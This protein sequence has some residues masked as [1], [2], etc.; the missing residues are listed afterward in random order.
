MPQ[1]SPRNMTICSRFG[2]VCFQNRFSRSDHQWKYGT[3]EIK[4]KTKVKNPKKCD[5]WHFYLH[6][7][8]LYM[9]MSAQLIFFIAILRLLSPRRLFKLLLLFC[10]FPS[11]PV[12]III[13][14]WDFRSLTTCW[15]ADLLTSHRFR[16]CIC[17]LILEGWWRSYGCGKPGFQPSVTRTVNLFLFFIIIIIRIPAAAST[18]Q[19]CLI[20]TFAYAG[21]LNKADVDSS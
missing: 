3:K 2:F 15:W 5:T 16:S 20:H 14:E 13:G 12:N 18:K 9:V 19:L 4:G 11:K 21:H 17:A 6:V 1:T 7:D 10:L 8:Y